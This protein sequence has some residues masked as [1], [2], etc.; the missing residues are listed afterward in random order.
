M[1]HSESIAKLAAALVKAQ[2]ELQ[3][4]IK[5]SK[6]PHFKSTFASLNS[7]L[8]TIKPVYAAHGLAVTQW[9][10]FKEGHATVTT[11]LVH[12]SGEWM[13]HEAGS[14]LQKNDPQGVGSAL[15]YLRRYGLAAVAGIG[16]EDDDGNAATV[17]NGA[18]VSAE[19]IANIEDWITESGA[20][21]AGFLKFL[22]VSNLADLPAKRYT[23]A[24]A[25]LKAKAEKVPA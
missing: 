11:M 18:T 19:Q 9:P 15:T 22:G 7:V 10:G 2:A 20:D 17:Q 4:A 5:D 12:E 24:I 25:A 13:R 14:P 16:Q 23:G 3:H 6:N 1:E 21:R 8:D